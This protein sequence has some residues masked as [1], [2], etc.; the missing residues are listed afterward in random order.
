MIKTVAV[1]S[2][3]GQPALVKAG[4]AGTP[5]GVLTEGELTDGLTVSRALKTLWAEHAVAGRRVS[6]GIGGESVYC[7]AD[8]IA[9]GRADEIDEYVKK[10]ALQVTG[11]PADNLCLGHQPVESMIEGAV[12]WTACMPRQV[13]WMRE[14]V[15]LAGK[16]PV[17]VT[18]QACALANVYSHAYQPSSQDAVLL[19]N[20]GARRLTMAV[21]R[22]WAV[23]FARDV[24]IGRDWGVDP[25]TSTERMFASI[26]YN[27]EEIERRARPLGL[28]RILI[29]GGAA[30][31][32]DLVDRLLDHTGLHVDRLEPFRRIALPKGS[33]ARQVAEEHAL[34][35]AVATGLALTGCEDL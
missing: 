24:S 13:D 33:T 10:R 11:L 19:L 17:M 3:G 22:G 6:A 23:A 4:V 12:L 30:R 29:S 16:S 21:V 28:S 15:S 20:I 14:T 1:E 35:L 9:S 2:R 32:S 27:W 26:D 25:A 18:P 5:A 8:V 31:R 34:S 7:Q